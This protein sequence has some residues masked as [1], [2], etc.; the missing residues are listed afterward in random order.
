MLVIRHLQV[1]IDGRPVLADLDLAIRAGKVHAVMGARGSG[2]STL[3]RVLAG[4]PGYAVNA[5]EVLYRGASLLEL[6]PEERAAQGI[7]LALQQPVEL[8]GVANLYFLRAAL[9]ALRRQRGQ[10]ELDAIDCLVAIRSKL[11]LLGMD[12]SLL[13]RPLNADFSDG[14]RKRNEILQMLLFEPALALLDDSAAG[15]D[16]DALKAVADGIN[17]L[18]SPQRAIV[19]FAHD[20]R[21]LHTVA[22]DRVHLLA[23]GRIVRSGGRELAGELE[24]SGYEPAGEL[25]EALQVRP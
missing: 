2:K 4:H 9:N 16:G 11:K 15:L 25:P 13:Y 20:F 17:A 18:R 8:P 3:A 19:L 14:D 10:P 5:G 21:L 1:S 24:G 12:E 6:A 7:F 23:D 22:P